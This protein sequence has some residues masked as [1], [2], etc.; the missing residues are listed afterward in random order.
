MYLPRLVSSRAVVK[1]SPIHQNCL[2][3]YAY[4]CCY[5]ISKVQ[6]QTFQLIR[7]A[8]SSHGKK[9]RTMLSLFI[10]LFTSRLRIADKLTLR[11][12]HYSHKPREYATNSQ[13]QT[14]NTQYD[15]PAQSQISVLHLP[16]KATHHAITW[17]LTCP[18]QQTRVSFLFAQ[19]STERLHLASAAA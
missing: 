11:W 18:S 12:R 7:S 13:V 19:I 17:L 5:Y 8:S 15:N 9:K 1:L 2:T 3:L 14:Y 16:V 6:H 10:P 4:R